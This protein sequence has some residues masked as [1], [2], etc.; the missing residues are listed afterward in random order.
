MGITNRRCK[1]PGKLRAAALAEV[2][3]IAQ[4]RDESKA[5]RI[6][7]F[8]A[9]IIL[10]CGGRDRHVFWP[11]AVLD[12]LID[13]LASCNL[14]YFDCLIARSRYH[15][16]VCTIYTFTLVAKDF[17]IHSVYMNRYFFLRSISDTHTHCHRSYREHYNG[18]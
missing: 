4:L 14:G 5:R 6:R 10:S 1:L 12:Y 3:N 11:V 2:Y 18:D 16:F 13:D 9:R 17:S 7:I 15:G 8:A